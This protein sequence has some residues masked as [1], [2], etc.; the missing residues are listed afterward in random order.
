MRSRSQM[1]AASGLPDVHPAL[2]RFLSRADGNCR[3][4]FIRS[5]AGT[6]RGYFAR[7]WLGNRSGEV[8]DWSG[9][10][11]DVVLAVDH[12]VQRLHSDPGLHLAVIL[13]PAA[14]IWALTS[15]T[16]CLVANQGDLLLNL[17]EIGQ[18]VG[19]ETRADQPDAHRLHQLTGGWL[20]ALLIL[21]DDPQASTRARQSIAGGLARWLAHRDPTGALG[22]AAFLPLF[23]GRTVEA[24]YGEFSPVVHTLEDLV[25]AGLV[26]PDGLG[27][28]MMPRMV[29][30]ILVERVGLRGSGRV[31]ALER[32]AV[33]AMAA[34]HGVEAAVDSAVAHRRWPALLDLLLEHWVDVFIG[35]PRQLD[36]IASKIPHFIAEQTEYMRV[37]LRILGSVDRQSISLRPPGLEPDYATNHTAQRLHQ[38]ALRL[39]NKPNAHAL[40]VGMLET[41]NLRMSGLYIEAGTA[42]ARLR[43]TLHRGLDAQRLNP[44]LVA[45][46][47]LQA[48]ISLYLA[49][50]DSEARQ[51]YESGFHWAQISGKAVLLADVTGKLALLNVLEGDSAAAARWLAEHDATIGDVSC[52]RGLVARCATMAR[53]YLALARLDYEGFEQTMDVLPPKPDHDE[54]WPVQAQQLALQKIN[55][56]N[57]EAAKTLISSLRAERRYTAASPLARRLFDDTLMLVEILQGGVMRRG[58]GAENRDP[59]L[60]ALGHLLNGNPDAALAALEDV[61]VTPGL[62]RRGNLALYL[63]LAARNPQGLTP[64]LVQ[65]L[66]RLHQES[67]VLYEL[68]I[69]GMVPG[70]SEVGR[71]VVLEPEEFQRL[72]YALDLAPAPMPKRPVLS[73]REQEVLR[74]L[75]AG[76]SRRQI[77][78]AGYRSENTVKTQMRSLYRKLEASDMEHALDN[79]RAWGL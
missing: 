33:N 5:A 51:A 15:R 72:G 73:A 63:D 71:S 19:S 14:S 17:A 7:S 24:F 55:V 76:M 56:G 77:A 58:G 47:E 29:R 59:L 40:T 30:Q 13:P 20:A 43:A 48:G 23:D 53:A 1:G 44:A 62:R 70:W 22:D 66:Q 21:S 54:F 11:I 37:G 42:A 65:R 49:G 46:T 74:Q 69:L 32:A 68:S 27:G 26:Q 31:V 12:L 18:F 75:R 10:G 41:V 61:P 34:I 50:K 78:E 45:L 67:G 60:V 28:W 35:N 52:G 2:P 6:G 9:G 39:A 38:D 64:E 25:Q 3:L 79:A 16:P 57:F 8:L 36:I 4:L